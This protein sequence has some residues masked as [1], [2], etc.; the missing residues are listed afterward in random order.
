MDLETF[1]DVDLQKCEVYKYAQ[2]PNFEILL[3]GVS[4]NGGEVMVY[5][6]AQGE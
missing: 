2:S 3:F 6:L 4:V 1:S 5:Y